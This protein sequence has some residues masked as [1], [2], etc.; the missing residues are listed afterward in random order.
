MQMELFLES[1]VLGVSLLKIGALRRKQQFWD[2]I[3][4]GALSHHLLPKIPAHKFVKILF[5][6]LANKQLCVVKEIS[7]I[8]K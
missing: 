3:D 1:L 8:F 6:Y 4:N 2:E 5:R 7:K